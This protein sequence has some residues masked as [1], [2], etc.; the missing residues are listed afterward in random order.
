MAKAY[1]LDL[2]ERVIAACDG[3]RSAADVAARYAVSESF[4][5]KL[6]RQR[7]ERGTLAPKPHAGGRK[8]L[9]TEHDDALRALLKAKPDSTL[10][11]V[12]TT[13][14]LQVQLSTLWY[15][16]DHLGLTFKK[17]R[18]GPPSKSVRTCACS[19]S[20]GKPNNRPWIRPS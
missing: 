19:G 12:R 11:E 13:L 7:R 2:R 8:P 1:S 16:L 9:L 5:E 14:R 20:P 3:G 10:E 15:C 17:K 18:S 6:K 4:I